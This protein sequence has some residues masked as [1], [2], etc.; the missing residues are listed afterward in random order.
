MFNL[1]KIKLRPFDDFQFIWLLVI[2]SILIFLSVSFL[3][4]V[5]P[6]P[7]K[8]R[9]TN[10]AS[11]S[12][13]VSWLT[14]RPTRGRLILTTQPNRF[15]RPFQFLIFKYFSSNCLTF[16][17]QIANPSTTHYLFLKNLKPKTAY[18]YRIFVNGRP[19]K[20]DGTGRLL[21]SLRT[22][23]V[24]ENLSMPKPLYSYLYEADGKTPIKNALIYLSF[25][26]SQTKEFSFQ[27]LAYFTDGQGAWLADLGNLA[28]SQGDLLLIELRTADGRQTAQFIRFNGQRKIKPII[29]K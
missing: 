1:K 14:D 17:D 21:P 22:A 23:P 12:L 9:I 5:P 25:M 20:H 11:S 24:L 15:W 3:S 26:G 29:L 7:K 10:I 13:V 4:Q 19:W 6:S 18:Y 2:A 27:K 8:V 16:S 28:V